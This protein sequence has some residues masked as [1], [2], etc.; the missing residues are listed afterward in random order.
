M[1]SVQA[2]RQPP[3]SPR[4]K[5]PAASGYGTRSRNRA[6]PRPN[7]AEEPD[8]DA[9][10]GLISPPSKRRATAS[11]SAAE[12]SARSRSP[13]SSG[14]DSDSDSD[15][16]SASPRPQGSADPH[17]HAHAYAYAHGHTHTHGRASAATR[18]HGSRKASS[19]VAAAAA[20]A[21]ASQGP[22]LEKSGR[23][24]RTSG[25][26]SAG[27]G[28]EKDARDDKAASHSHRTTSGDPPG[29]RGTAGPESKA[30]SPSP[31]TLGPAHSSSGARKRKHPA[32]AANGTAN[33]RDLI[34]IN[35]KRS[36][37]APSRARTR[38]GSSISARNMMSFENS[39]ARL[40]DG[41][42]IAD[43]GTSIAVNGTPSYFHLSSPPHP[44]HLASSC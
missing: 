43:D 41:K 13:R 27:K 12:S 2:A 25:L 29:S 19:H 35:P 6:A 38:V 42:L 7:Y 23:G 34:P 4:P 20:A 33:H 11:A 3:R 18:G 14:S 28:R 10:F 37:I 1:P 5:F 36:Y 32:S 44:T 8:L 15:S 30:A 31:A 22:P 21:A 26:V 16:D 17:A 39:Q 40:Q 24:R 9:S